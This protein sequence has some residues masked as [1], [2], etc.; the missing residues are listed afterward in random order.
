MVGL[1]NA[2]RNG[3]HRFGHADAGGRVPADEQAVQLDFVVGPDLQRIAQLQQETQDTGAHCL[4]DLAGAQLA[5]ESAQT[6]NDCAEPAA[7]GV[8]LAAGRSQDDCRR[9]N[10]G[11][12]GAQSFALGQRAVEHFVQRGFGTGNRVADVVAAKDGLVEKAQIA[13][14]HRHLER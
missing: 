7:T 12:V 5:V 6:D 10:L 4:S 8:F 9:A 3:R 11:G 14:A 2:A 1:E 13:G